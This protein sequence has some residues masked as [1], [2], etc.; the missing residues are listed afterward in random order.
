MN[1][2]PVR[3]TWVHSRFLEVVHVTWSLVFCLVFCRSLFVLLCPVWHLYFFDIRILI[4]PLVTSNSFQCGAVTAHYFGA[5]QLL[6]GSC[7]SIF[8]FLCSVLMTIPYRIFILLLVIAL[9][10]LLRLTASGCSFLVS[11]KF[12]VCV[13]LPSVARYTRY[14]TMCHYL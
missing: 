14:T 12:F 2:L 1:C 7:C 3:S 4:T 11:S 9:S 10:V 5:P 13:R 8:S 6:R